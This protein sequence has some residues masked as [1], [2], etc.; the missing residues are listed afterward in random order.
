MNVWKQNLRKNTIRESISFT[1][2]LR[3]DRLS[4][5]HI[6]ML[7]WFWCKIIYKILE[8]WLRGTLK[9]VAA[10][11]HQLISHHHSQVTT[12]NYL[13]WHQKQVKQ[14]EA[15]VVAKTH[16]QDRILVIVKVYQ[17]VV[18]ENMEKTVPSNILLSVN[19][20]TNSIWIVRKRQLR[21]WES[22][23]SLL[24]SWKWQ[25][26]TNHK[27]WLIFNQVKL[28]KALFYQM[29]ASLRVRVITICIKT[30]VIEINLWQ[31]SSCLKLIQEE[32]LG[33][34]HSHHFNNTKMAKNLLPKV[35]LT[36]EISIMQ[37]VEME[38]FL[39]PFSKTKIEW[40]QQRTI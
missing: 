38:D 31:R 24:P 8:L 5:A 3:W 28:C 26:T 40:Q 29:W 39:N 2:E 10:S 1:R 37:E 27:I 25:M 12:C 9:E 21:W 14:K 13:E 19:N 20:I 22:S 18:L 16:I 33:T 4:R 34:T 17:E 30:M 15:S 11:M 32:S 7:I 36:L 35:D 6:K 23:T